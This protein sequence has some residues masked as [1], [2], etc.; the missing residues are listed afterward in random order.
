MAM[1]NYDYD[2]KLASKF[3]GNKNVMLVLRLG[4]LK[5]AFELRL[6]SQF[7]IAIDISLIYSVN[8]T[9]QCNGYLVERQ[10]FRFEFSNMLSA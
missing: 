2:D 1:W 10:M 5:E 9:F 3:R 7:G 4:I 8:E 6:L